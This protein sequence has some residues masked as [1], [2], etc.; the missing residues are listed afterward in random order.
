[1]EPPKKK[2]KRE[3]T[4]KPAADGRL[5]SLNWLRAID[6]LENRSDFF[7]RVFQQSPLLREGCPELQLQLQEAESGWGTDDLCTQDIAEIMRMC[8]VAPARLPEGV[9]VLQMKNQQPQAEGFYSS[10]YEAF[11]DS[12]SMIVN[13]AE[14]CGWELELELEVEVQVQVQEE[15]EVE[16]EVGVRG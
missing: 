4:Q 6:C 14:R 7:S 5:P 11:L 15:V 12:C 13:H 16:V 8:S 10:C 1:M 2:A 3:E 9:G